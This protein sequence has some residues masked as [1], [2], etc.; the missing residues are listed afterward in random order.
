ML[1]FNVIV[2]TVYANELTL[3]KYQTSY[4]DLLDGLRLSLRGYQ[5]E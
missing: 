2:V 1:S 4:N 5:M 3:D